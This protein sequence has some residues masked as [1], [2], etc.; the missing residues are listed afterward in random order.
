MVVEEFVFLHHA[1]CVTLSEEWLIALRL[2]CGPREPPK[3][4]ALGALAAS[5]GLGLCLRSG[6]RIGIK[7]PSI[8]S[9]QALK[10]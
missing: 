9:G 4:W 6:P 7:L 5:P 2:L 8:R 3:P 1:P 10:P